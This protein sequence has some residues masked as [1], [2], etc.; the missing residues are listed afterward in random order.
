[1]KSTQCLL[2]FFVAQYAKLHVYEVCQGNALLLGDQLMEALDDFVEDV[3]G[4]RQIVLGAR[5]STTTT[6]TTA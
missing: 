1:V 4:V 5:T 3:L 6:T 2:A